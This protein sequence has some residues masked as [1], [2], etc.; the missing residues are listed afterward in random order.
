MSVEAIATALH[1][2]RATATAK[3]VL[4]G[5]ANHVGDGGAWPSVATLARYAN[6]HPRKVQEAIVKLEAL[7][8]V[9]RD[10]QG[11]GNVTMRRN[12]R[13]NLYRFTLRCPPECDG[14]AQHRIRGAENGTPA[15][16]GTPRGAESG[17]R[18]VLMNRDYLSTES[19]HDSYASDVVTDSAPSS[20]FQ[21][22]SAA[23]S[24]LIDVPEI[25]AAIHKRTGIRISGDRA[26]GV[27]NWI[28]DK[29]VHPPRAPQRYVLAA[30]E[31]S[32]AEIEQHL[33]RFG[34]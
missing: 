10:I 15:E 12:Q 2:S 8:E 1:H 34:A 22:R 32:P 6:V 19:S 4:I 24:G 11:G 16:S 13:P 17:A 9:E 20:R 14:S 26:I 28:L 21:E 7:G 23:R 29:S 31:K 27:S 3:V 25:V 33:Y 30:I 5:I 18:T